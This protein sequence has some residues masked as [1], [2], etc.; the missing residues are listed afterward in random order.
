MVAVPAG[1]FL[2][3]HDSGPRSCRPQRRVFLDA[4][5]IDR[6]EVTNAAFAA[7]VAATGWQS[8]GWDPGPAA[9]QP[10]HPVV[11][12][13]WRG[14]QAYCRWAGKRLPTEAEWERA[15]R[16]ADGR[17]Y[18]WGDAWVPGKANTSESGLGGVVAVGR[19]PTG[20]SPAGVLDM[21]GNAAEWVADYF[22][23]DYYQAAPDRNPAGPSQ[24]LDHGIRGGSWA[25]PASEALTYMRDS[26]HSVSPNPRVGFR[27]A[28]SETSS[29]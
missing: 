22:D 20:A 9:R 8:A 11:G 18:P 28:R 13:L 24:V 10:D 4:Y 12:V 19:F 27:C 1:W 16:G 2:M 3:G 14:A 25:S 29:P 21:A 26:S 15:A 6:T 5:E 7:F 17:S 23:P